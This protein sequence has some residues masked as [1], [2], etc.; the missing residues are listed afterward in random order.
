MTSSNFV[1]VTTYTR[2]P[3][4]S[5]DLEF[6]GVHRLMDARANSESLRYHPPPQQ[7]TLNVNLCIDGSP[8]D[9]DPV[10]AQGQSHP[11]LPTLSMHATAQPISKC[12]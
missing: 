2:V 7:L 5:I 1:I 3:R 6:S 12:H 11:S 9:R 4:R 10:D 8:P